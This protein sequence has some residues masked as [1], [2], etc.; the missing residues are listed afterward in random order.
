MLDPDPNDGHLSLGSVAGINNTVGRRDPEFQ[1]A[2]AACRA[3]LPPGVADDGTGP[4]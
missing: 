3:Q 2:D 1:T 4:P